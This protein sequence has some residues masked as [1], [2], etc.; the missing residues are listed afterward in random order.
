MA[1]HELCFCRT[2]VDK[3]EPSQILLALED[4]PCKLRCS[5]ESMRFGLRTPGG[6]PDSGSHWQEAKWGQVESLRAVLR[7]QKETQNWI[8]GYHTREK[9]LINSKALLESNVQ[10]N[11]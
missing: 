7:P 6:S 10:K 2:D 3:I 5:Q 4:G 11:S 8:I 1:I 9:Y